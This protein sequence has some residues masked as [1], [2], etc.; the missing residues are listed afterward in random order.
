MTSF[1]KNLTEKLP[2]QAHKRVLT[3]D[4]SLHLNGVNDDSIFALGDCATIENPNLV[5][6]IMDIFENA[7]A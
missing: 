2:E 5:E 3:T 7:D 1:A 6:H 4:A